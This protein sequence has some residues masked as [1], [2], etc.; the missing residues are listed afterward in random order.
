MPGTMTSA[1]NTPAGA[2]RP[3]VAAGTTPLSASG[4]ELAGAGPADGGA[5]LPEW[6]MLA[7]TGRWMGHPTMPEVV[8]EAHL[9]SAQAHFQRHYAANG[10]DLVVDYHHASIAAPSAEAPAAGWVKQMELRNGG[11][12]LWGRVMWTSRAAGAIAR[13]E[14]RYVSPVFRFN[15]PDRLSGETVPLHIHSVALTNTPFLTELQSLN[16]NSPLPKGADDMSI[17]D[18]VAA[19]L[20]TTPP[21]LAE[22]LELDEDADDRAIAEAL[23][24]HRPCEVCAEVANSLQIEPA[25]DGTD[26]R[27]ALIRL[28]AAREGMNSVRTKLGLAEDAP[29]TEVLNAIDGLLQRQ[30]RSEA[31]RLVEKA[32]ED[33]RIPPAHRDFYLRE[34]LN[35]L[36]AAGQVINSLPVL[37]AAQPTPGD[38]AAA[39]LSDG[40]HAV[41][42]QLGL[43]PDQMAAARD[44]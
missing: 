29:E 19:A 37:T 11:T 36:S 18:S 34:A 4:D 3:R 25:A 16:S 2:A 13:S 39:A 43:S 41:C 38:R 26:L 1:E 7:R 20:E 44:A 21:E 10:A 8:D 22:R 31:E 32:I 28:K 27:A 30:D 35:D 9:L 5:S 24:G 40:E 6:I 15:H 17:L 42:R 23:V 14:Y 33:G 12:E